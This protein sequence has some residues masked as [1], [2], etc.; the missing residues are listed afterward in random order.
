MS[1]IETGG[2]GPNFSVVNEVFPFDR[3]RSRM[4]DKQMMDRSW[5]TDLSHSFADP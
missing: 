5:R 2:K 3:W 1:A 4:V